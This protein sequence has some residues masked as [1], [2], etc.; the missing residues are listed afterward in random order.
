[1]DEIINSLKHT[2]DSMLNS[3]TVMDYYG[4]LDSNLH[5]A[6]KEMLGAMQIVSEWISDLEGENDSNTVK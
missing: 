3:A 4:G 5:D 1:M 2:R 6:S